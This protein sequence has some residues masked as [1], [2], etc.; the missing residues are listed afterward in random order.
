M[1]KLRRSRLLAACSLV[2]AGG[3]SAQFALI[4]DFEGFAPGDQVGA[5]AGEPAAADGFVRFGPAE[6]GFVVPGRD[7][8]SANV[9]DGGADGLSAVFHEGGFRV[10]EG[11]RGTL[12]YQFQIVDSGPD[13]VFTIGSSLGLPSAEFSFAVPPDDFT[14]TLRAGEGPSATQT[15]LPVA[16]NSLYSVY[17][18]IDNGVGADDAV[19][20]FLQSDED[21]F[22]EEL[23]EVAP[24]GSFRRPQAALDGPV[25]YDVFG[26]QSFGGAGVGDVL[27]D[28][29]FFADGVITTADPFSSPVPEPAAAALMGAGALAL[30]RRRR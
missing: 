25:D 29:I 10:E 9:G 24:G 12:F 26:F 22:Y 1:S 20:V 30:L 3:A 7:G 8:L 13:A 2:C 6:N 19:S 18:A 11:S 28:N 16:L 15:D 27:V 23:T 21:L 14:S 17:I 4:Q 5:R